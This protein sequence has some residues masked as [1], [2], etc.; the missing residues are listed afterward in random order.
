M[1]RFML[2]ITSALI[3]VGVGAAMSL[4]SAG[5]FSAKTHAA[6]AH[7]KKCHCRRGRRGRRGPAGA[8][9]PAGQAGQAGPAGPAGPVG[10]TGPAGGGSS[11]VFLPAPTHLG[12]FGQAGFIVGNW[13]IGVKTDGSGNCTGGGFI[14]GDS[15]GQYYVRED[16]GNFG[17][18][19]GFTN[20]NEALEAA[21]PTGPGTNPGMWNTT[22]AG[23]APKDYNLN[24][25]A[26]GGPAPVGN[27]LFST[28]G[29]SSRAD[30]SGG[31][32][33][34]QLVT[35]DG[36]SQ[37]GGQLGCYTKSTGTTVSGFVVGQ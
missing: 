11:N 23:S 1:K 26:L 24:V 16:K 12:T 8:R 3:I 28:S 36:S 13:T 2:L 22:P 34:F 14:T 5:A 7:G 30:Q 4:P 32:A 31:N 6:K 9:G 35:N 21:G 37:A 10:A 19:A 20:E 33:S 29:D 15:S 25:P 17:P 18:A 27:V